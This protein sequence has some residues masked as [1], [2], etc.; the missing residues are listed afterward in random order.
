MHTLNNLKLLKAD[1]QSK[2]WVVEGFY[3]KYKQKSYIVIVKLFDKSEKIPEYALVKLEF[4][5]KSNFTNMLSTYAN[6]VKLFCTAKELRLFF[7]IEYSDNMGDIIEQ[8]YQR[9][10]AYIPAECSNNRS[11]E[12]K[13]AMIASLNRSDS[14]DPNRIYCYKVKRNA[15]S[16]DGVLGQRSCYNDN[17]TRLR[18]G[19]LYSRLGED[20][21]ISFCYSTNIDDERT[22]EQIISDFLTHLF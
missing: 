16:K 11:E 10:S 14:E 12:L 5:E 15:K 18:R 7:G 1:M 20:K 17:K 21:N 22:D 19:S 8:F 9:L 2:G 3:Y 6:S 13:K 4:L